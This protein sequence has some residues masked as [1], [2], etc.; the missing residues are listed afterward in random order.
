M[1]PDG[2]MPPSPPT[3]KALPHIITH[4][5][6]PGLREDALASPRVAIVAGRGTPREDRLPVAHLCLREVLVG[7]Q[8]IWGDEA[9][10]GPHLRHEAVE[11]EVEDL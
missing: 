3:Q 11:A 5:H 2:H 1:L 9:L 10:P 8:E 6:T 4:L 7:P